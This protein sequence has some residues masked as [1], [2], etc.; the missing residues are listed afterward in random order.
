MD[1]CRIIGRSVVEL[2]IHFMET[3]AIDPPP[4][5]NFFEPES[6]EGVGVQWDGGDG[7]GAQSR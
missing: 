6:K 7:P 3:G 5:L 1:S 2:V 4:F